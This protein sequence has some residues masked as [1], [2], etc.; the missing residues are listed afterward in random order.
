MAESAYQCLAMQQG[1]SLEVH[2]AKPHIPGDDEVLIKIKAIAL[3]P[4]DW[5]QIDFGINIS[6]WPCVLGGDGS[7]TVVAVGKSVAGFTT[8]DS[9][10]ASFSSGQDHSAAFQSHAAVNAIKVAKKPT[11]MSF[12][13]AA[14]L[15]I[16]YVTA[17]GAIYQGLN[18]PLP[19]LEGGKEEGF[20]PSSILVCGGS[21]SVG[22]MAVQLL[23]LALPKAQILATASKQHHHTVK[24]LGADQVFDH[25][26][27][28]LVEELKKASSSGEGVD[29]ILDAVNGVAVNPSLFE[30]LTGPKAFAEVVTGR[31]VEKAPDG[32]KHSPVFGATVYGQPGGSNLFAALERLLAEGKLK[33]PTAVKVVG[34]GLESLSGGL[35]ELRAG[36]SG[37]KLVV[38]L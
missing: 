18:I 19:Y 15:P 1:G 6:K 38:S 36:V 13:D 29:A 3:N 31:N 11:P 21:S 27:P 10:L 28:S 30:V 25:S 33:L 34:H 37:T 32:V 4:I 16:S 26:S 9:V 12:E 5:K 17:T 14:T 7:G 8:G 23:R 2:E 24:S 22:A 20:K 35:E